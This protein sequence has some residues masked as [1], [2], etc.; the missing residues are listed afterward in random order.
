MNLTGWKPIPRLTKQELN[1]IASNA[2]P[3]TLAFFVAGPG[4][5]GDLQWL[6]DMRG[7]LR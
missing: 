4:Q 3:K 2:Q 1:G 7:P 5:V 6:F